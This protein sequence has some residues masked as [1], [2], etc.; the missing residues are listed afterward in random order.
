MSRLDF[1]CHFDLG[2]VQKKYIFRPND[3]RA[4]YFPLI[5]ESGFIQMATIKSVD[6][7]ILINEEVVLKDRSYKL[8]KHRDFFVLT[9]K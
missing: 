1:Q 7:E 8:Q 2:L 9:G 6:D 4:I 5:G 3:E